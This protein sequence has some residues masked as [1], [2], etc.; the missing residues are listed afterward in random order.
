VSSL[1]LI[2][3][4]LDQV[5]G[6]ASISWVQPRVLGQNQIGELAVR[7]DKWCKRLGEVE[8]RVSA[9]AVGAPAGL[10]GATATAVGA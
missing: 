5:A 6:T 1:K 7:L 9:D 3:G 2:R 4:T 8:N 10:S